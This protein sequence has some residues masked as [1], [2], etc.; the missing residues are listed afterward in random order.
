MHGALKDNMIVVDATVMADFFIGSEE[1]QAAAKRLLA[2]DAYWVSPS[3]WRYELGN[4]LRTG[5]RARDSVLAPA[6]ALKHMQL[7][8]SLVVETI[9]DLDGPQILTLSLQRGLTMYDASYVWVAK[10][11]GLKL[12]TRDAE[13]LKFCP[14]IASPMPG[15]ES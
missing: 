2:E 7:A 15:M 9:E 13:V 3:L 4:V 12:R 5:V 14:E 6:T 10:L 11:R 8:E 1:R